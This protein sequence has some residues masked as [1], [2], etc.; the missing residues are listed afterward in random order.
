MSR[1]QL[2][3]GVPGKGNST[4]LKSM[5]CSKNTGLHGEGIRAKLDER[6]ASPVALVAENLPAN[7]GD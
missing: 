4:M 2:G 5:V 6:T 3:G 1:E 7:E